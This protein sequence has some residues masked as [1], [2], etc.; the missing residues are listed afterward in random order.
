[1]AATVRRTKIEKLGIGAS[2]G[3]MT[4][5]ERQHVRAFRRAIRKFTQNA[6][7]SQAAAMKTLIDAGLYTAQGKPKKQFR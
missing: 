2:K 3:L 7:R 6:V 5:S 4:A 1:M